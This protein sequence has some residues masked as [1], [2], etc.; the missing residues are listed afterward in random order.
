MF[1]RHLFICT[2]LKPDGKPSCA[3]KGAETLRDRVKQ[4]ASR[5]AA[6]SP[7]RKIRVNASGCLGQCA[8]GIA[9]VC[10]P[11]GTWLTELADDSASEA[12]L[13]ALLQD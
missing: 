1:D 12:R 4:A 11:Q 8:Q 13:L 3:A 6:A 7:G 5:L 10:Y 2:N 9:A